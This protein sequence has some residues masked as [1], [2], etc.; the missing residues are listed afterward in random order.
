[1]QFI[2][3]KIKLL[4]QNTL[5]KMQPKPDP[6]AELLFYRKSGNNKIFKKK[7]FDSETANFKLSFSKKNQIEFPASL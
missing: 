1:M 4:S 3:I 6:Q 2:K 5:R 7:S